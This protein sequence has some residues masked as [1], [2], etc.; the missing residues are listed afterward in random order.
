MKIVFATR[1]AG[2]VAELTELLAEA[3]PPLSSWEVLTLDA[4]PDAP[5]V[6]ESGETFA[7]N[8]LL[9]ARAIATHCGLPALA[10]DSGLCVDAL[11]GRPGVHSARYGGDDATNAQRI[12]K[13]LAELGDLADA[14]RGAAF[15][16]VLSFVREAQGEPIVTE[17]SCRGRILRAPTGEGGFGY[18][19]IFYSDALKKSFALASRA[20]KASVSHRGVA[21]RKMV[22]ALASID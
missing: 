1:N 21:M 6:E 5:A 7:E 4:F 15:R 20:E 2:K 18:D 3:G 17:G 8:S 12:E 13:L 10:D 16:C 19:P 11:G 9:K 14:E 22:R